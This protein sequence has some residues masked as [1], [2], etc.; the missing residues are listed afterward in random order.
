[1]NESSVLIGI[2]V[3][4][5]SPWLQRTLDSLDSLDYPKDR[6]RIVFL[7]GNSI[8]ETLDIL[9]DYVSHNSRAEVYKEPIDEGLQ[10]ARDHLGAYL[11]NDFK[12]VLRD[13]DYFLYLSS[14][15]VKIPSNLLKELIRVNSDIIAP[16][17]WTEDKKY[18]Y[19]TWH[20]RCN[21][22][23]F[24][25]NDPPGKN[26]T[27][28]IYVDTVGGCVLIRENV[29]RSI[30]FSNPYPLLQFCESARK[31]G[32]KVLACPYLEVEHFDMNKIG[33]VRKP[34]PQ[35]MGG[36]PLPGFVDSSYPV[37]EYIIKSSEEIISEHMREALDIA[38]EIVG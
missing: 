8:D 5:C 20:F 21:G 6:L 33:I 38:K 31:V 14:E 18:Y 28:P 15:I 11:F 9:R 7:Y 2:P 10:R 35:E 25:P 29:F 24:H 17:V 34:L 27:T 16:Y 36:W 30:P 4:N 19:D 13:E 37:K 26:C 23:R 1:M 22:Y 12:E 3:H 32:Y